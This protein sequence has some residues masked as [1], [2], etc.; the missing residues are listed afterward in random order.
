MPAIGLEALERCRY[1]TPLFDD[2]GLLTV[3]NDLRQS[4]VAVKQL[5]HF[6]AVAEDVIAQ[7][8]REAAAVQEDLQRRIALR[9]DRVAPPGDQ[10]HHVAVILGPRRNLLGEIG[11]SFEQLNV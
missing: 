6:A 5:Y 7:R 2:D 11:H 10:L 3:A 9:Y 4:L 8:Q 1:T